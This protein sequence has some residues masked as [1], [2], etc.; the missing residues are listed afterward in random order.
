MDYKKEYDK[1]VLQ[2]KTLYNTTSHKDVR[3]AIKEIRPELAEEREE[4]IRKTVLE[5]LN[6]YDET[7]EI[8]GVSK[9]DMIAWVK[10]Q[11]IRKE[12]AL[13]DISIRKM[14]DEYAHNP[15]AGNEE[16]GTPV[17]CMVRAY[18]N[19]IRNV[20][21]ILKEEKKIGW[22]DEVLKWLAANIKKYLNSDYNV[23]H[24]AIEYDGTVNTE[25][26]IS[27]LKN[28]FYISPSE[29]RWQPDAKQMYALKNASTDGVL[30]PNTNM[31][32]KTLY[33]DLKRAYNIS[34]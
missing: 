8:D 31:V 21:S 9:S 23:F 4:V 17:N 33:D 14:V 24:R 7:Y 26:L 32:I 6:R 34:D 11:N 19:G 12:I 10:K 13:D 3:E 18:E 1:L 5:L 2:L 25:K 15:E 28:N 29:E 16:F 27:D 30:S 20:L 22:N